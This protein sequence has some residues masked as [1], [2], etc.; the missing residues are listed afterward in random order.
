[1]AVISVHKYS[2]EKEN[3]K[4]QALGTRVMWPLHEKGIQCLWTENRNRLPHPHTQLVTK[5]AHLPMSA[6]TALCMLPLSSLA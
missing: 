1:M 5:N 6:V 2:P 4:A 3:C